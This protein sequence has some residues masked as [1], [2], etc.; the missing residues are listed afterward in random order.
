MRRSLVSYVACLSVSLAVLCVGCARKDGKVV[1]AE[2]HIHAGNSYLADL[3]LD[4]AL[5]E[6]EKARVIAPDHLPIYLRIGAIYA[7][8][9]RFKKAVE[10]FQF[11]LERDPESAEAYQY[12][13]RTL[14]RQG[15]FA[16]ALPKFERS[17]E[18]DP[19]VPEVFRRWGLTLVKLGRNAEAVSVFDQAAELDENPPA[20][21]LAHWGTALQHLGRRSD[22]IAKYEAALEVVPDHFTATNNLGL[23]LVRRASERARGIRLLENAVK[24]RPGSPATLHNLGWAYLEAERYPEAYNL[25]QRAVASTDPASPLYAERL[26]RLKLAE[27]ELPRREAAPAMPNVLMVV[28]DTLRADHVSAY[29]Y[30][31][32]TTPHLDA[33]ARQG[34]VL[35]NAI[36]QAPWTAASVASLF[37]GL[38]PSVHGLDGG[39][40]WGPGQRSAGGTLPFAVQKVLSSGQLTLAEVFRRNG[41]RTA[42]FVSNVY[43][44]SIFGF[45][46]GFELYND[47]HEEYS[48]NVSGAKRRAQETNRHVFEWLDQKPEEPFFLLVHYNDCHWPYNPPAPFGRDY[49][50]GYEGDLTPSRTTSIVETQ[51]QPVKGLSDEDLAYLVGLYDGE[52]AYM[53]SQLGALLKKLGSLGL[54]RKLASVV[55]ADHG[56]EFLDHGSASHGYT[57]YEEMIRVPLVFHYPGRL[58][59][60]RV[61]AQVRLID[62]APTLFALAAIEEEIPS[63][64]QG[65]NFLPL[66]QGKT[67]SGIDEAFS[68]A[69]YVGQKKAL[70]TQ[71]G[72]KLIYSFAQD[73]AMLFDLKA[74][75]GEKKSLLNGDPSKG[76][77]LREHLDLWVQANQATRGVLYG[78]EGP[79][80][81][82]VLDKETK[83]RLEALGYIQ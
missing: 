52:I 32:K 34:V 83:E 66:L 31:R 49:V 14:L 7:A 80:Q 17:A 67:A 9:G 38:Y 59:P 37:T 6:F 35:E 62:V 63:G 50:A 47:E 72:L 73:K 64:M 53:D 41:Y 61:E 82:V 57:L 75:P 58:A 33:L 21:S 29:G 23:L 43:V 76:E 77:P 36:S 4:L 12:W 71:N 48:K 22:A 79:D 74:D 8:K 20:D 24:A 19:S 42:G 25:L 2:Q 5:A 3:K 28:I 40:R 10:N 46:Q 65:R 11:V 13:G 56:E 39:I 30:A 16:Q 78:A 69:T 54:T 27:A 68:E 60:R 81:E 51:G 70:R 55:T 18:L 45:S 15:R 44:N 26:N 1:L